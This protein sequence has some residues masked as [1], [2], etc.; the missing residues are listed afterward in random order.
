MKVKVI[1]PNK[2]LSE[3]EI[4]KA[5]VPGTEGYFQRDGNLI[6]GIFSTSI[7]GCWNGRLI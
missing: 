6:R 1:L 2:T 4:D 3:S 5:T 7:P